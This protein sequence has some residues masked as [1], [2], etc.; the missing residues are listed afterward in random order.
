MKYEYLIFNII[1]IAGPLIFG[2]MKKFYFLNRIRE[3]LIAISVPI[4]PFLIWD[5]MVT[6]RHWFFNNNYVIGIYY[7][8]LPIEEIMFFVTVPFACVFTWEMINRFTKNIDLK[9]PVEIY[10]L[11]IIF[12]LLSIYMLIL[13]KEYTSL[14]FVALTLTF[15]YDRV[16]N[17]KFFLMKNVP[18]YLSLI[19]IFT[20]IFNG[21]L[22]YRPVIT[23]DEQ[24]QLAFRIFTIPVEDFLFG[25]SLLIIST[26]TYVK[27]T[28]G[29]K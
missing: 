3:T 14:V 21:Y 29:K 28:N 1:V 23:Y 9:F 17:T 2:S 10:F 7:F 8:G 4:I 19:T 22:T 15:I 20:I 5:A 26:I 11:P 13:G 27:L 18:L 16:L 6:D 12:F 25:F 24:Y